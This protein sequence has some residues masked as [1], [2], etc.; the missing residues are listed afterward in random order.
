MNVEKEFE[1]QIYL[2]HIRLN[3]LTGYLFVLKARYALMVKAQLSSK[4]SGIAYLKNIYMKC[5]SHSWSLECIKISL[6]QT[7]Y[8][9]FVY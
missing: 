8:F 4:D 2:K 3:S 9:H 7:Y 5:V 1:A 6:F